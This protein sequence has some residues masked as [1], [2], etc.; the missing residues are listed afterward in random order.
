MVTMGF[1]TVAAYGLW[2]VRELVWYTPSTESL[3]DFLQK[4]THVIQKEG[5]KGAIAVTF[6]YLSES[7]YYFG[8]YCGDGSQSTTILQ[9]AK[10][11][12]KRVILSRNHGYNLS[13]LGM[14]FVPDLSNFSMKHVSEYSV[15]QAI[16]ICISTRLRRC[17]Q[18]ISLNWR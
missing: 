15:P 8:G 3:H 1:S 7:R 17:L 16:C 9:S 6:C 18:A 14:K 13:V 5:I 12:S 2:L 11:R 4:V 10:D